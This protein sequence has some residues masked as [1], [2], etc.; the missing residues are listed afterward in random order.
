M[1]NLVISNKMVYKNTDLT[2]RPIEPQ[3]LHRNNRYKLYNSLRIVASHTDRQA[4]LQ[5]THLITHLI[6]INDL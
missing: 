4:V 1:S 6:W 5:Q 2:P 3:T